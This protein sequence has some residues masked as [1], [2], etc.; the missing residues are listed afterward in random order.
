M[1]STL[2]A[3]KFVNVTILGFPLVPAKQLKFVVEGVANASTSKTEIG[4]IVSSTHP[5]L[6]VTDKVIV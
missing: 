1:L 4:I 6:S 3:D 2:Y 5:L